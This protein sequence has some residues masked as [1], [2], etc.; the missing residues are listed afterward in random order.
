MAF[1][2]EKIKLRRVDYR[3]RRSSFPFT[4]FFFLVLILGGYLLYKHMPELPEIED[5]VPAPVQKLVLLGFEGADPNLI[6]RYWSDLP[7]LRALER[8]AIVGQSPRPFRRKDRL[9]GLPLPWEPDR[10]STGY[11]IL[12]TVSPEPTPFLRNC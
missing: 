10:R 9:R 7:H 2:P 12:F 1:K 3:R 11:S 5:T 4:T 8:A 6:D